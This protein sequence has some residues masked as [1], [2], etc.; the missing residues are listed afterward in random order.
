MPEHSHR[1]LPFTPRMPPLSHQAAFLDEHALDKH[2][3]LLWEQGT[4]KTKALI[5]NAA[6]LVMS[7]LIDGVLLLAPNGVHYNWVKEEL[8]KH[9]PHDA[10]PYRPYFWDTNKAGNKSAQ[11][12]YADFLSSNHMPWL[13][14]SYDGIVTEAGRQ[15]T[16]DFIRTRR[17]LYIADESQRI[18][19]PQLA[20]KNKVERTA[21]VTKSAV[22]A[23]YRRIASGTPMDKP[24]DIYSQMR[25]LDPD[26]W[27]RKLGL[28]SFTAFRAMFAEYETRYGAGGRTYPEFKAYRR[29]D[30]LAGAISGT[31]QRVL[32]EDVLDLP[33]KSY[34]RLFHELTPAQR[35]AYRELRSEAQTILL[36]GEVVT[37]EMAL[38]LQLR[39]AQI[40]CGFVKPG[41]GQAEVPFAQNPRAELLKETLRD[42]T[43]PAI[44]WG[45]FKYDVRVIEAASHAAGRR[46][47]VYDGS[48]PGD[49]MD[50]FHRGDADDIIANLS[51]NMIEGYTLNEADSTVYYSRT[52]KLITRLQSEDRNHR[53]GQGRPVT[54]YDLLASG[55]KEAEELSVLRGKRSSVG[56]VMGDDPRVALEWLVEEGTDEGE[57]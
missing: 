27:V 53:I 32:K 18:K 38:V 56:T 26:F 1:A 37:A 44:I 33:R 23:A 16:W 49:S 47:V 21:V 45:R 35:T 20:G 43:R 7:G 57:D 30:E 51:S 31:T 3:G 2:Y 42:L 8:P 41:P 55:T 10:P 4:G 17:V 12:E 25:F 14:M 28:G 50:P 39:L 5:D 11:R 52:P 6:L 46:P 13:C 22:Y 15:A 29:L 24:F 34:K 19:T 48:R 40:G 54:Y 9:W 36:A